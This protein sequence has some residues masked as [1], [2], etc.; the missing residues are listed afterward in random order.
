MSWVKIV[1]AVLLH[2]L[3]PR[4]FNRREGVEVVQ[5]NLLKLSL[6]PA[7]AEAGSHPEW[8]GLGSGA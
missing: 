6:V 7:S 3:K 2:I 8:N 4:K 5:L 1:H